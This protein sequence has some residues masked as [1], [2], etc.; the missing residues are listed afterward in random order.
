MRAAMGAYYQDALEGT[1]GRAGGAF[2]LS[3]GRPM[4]DLQGERDEAAG[5]VTT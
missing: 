4:P 1:H 2:S 5:S 3:G